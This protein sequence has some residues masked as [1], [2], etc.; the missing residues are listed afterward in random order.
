MHF[1]MVQSRHPERNGLIV[2]PRFEGG[3]EMDAT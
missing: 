2:P 1:A 3:L